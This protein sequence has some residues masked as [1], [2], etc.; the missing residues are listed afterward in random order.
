MSPVFTKGKLK[1]MGKDGPSRGRLRPLEAS[2][3]S[4]GR[5]GKEVVDAGDGLNKK[6]GFEI[7]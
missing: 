2:G 4:L 6:T 1:G 5:W 7:L 3:N